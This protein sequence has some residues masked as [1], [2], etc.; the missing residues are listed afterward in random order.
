MTEDNI[1]IES[2]REK[3]T[4]GTLYVMRER[5]Y[6]TGQELDYYKIGIVRGVKDVDDRLKDHLT[7]NPRD[8]FTVREFTSL[9]VQKLET[10]LH[11]LYAAHRVHSGEWFTLT[12]SEVG[13]LLDEIPKWQ[14]LIDSKYLEIEGKPLPKGPGSEQIIQPDENTSE[15]AQNLAVA[16][17]ELKIAKANKSLVS[18]K[19]VE[20]AGDNPEFAAMFKTSTSNS[21]GSFSSG[22]VEARDKALWESFMTL[23]S[24]TVAPKWTVSTPEG[25]K[26]TTNKI[27]RNA[28]TDNPSELHELF[29]EAWGVEYRWKLE[30]DLIEDVLLVRAA[31][32]A[33]IE[34]IF[35]W[36]T[37][38]SKGFDKEGF[39]LKHP[40]I[41]E[42]CIPP[43]KTT[44]KPIPAEW[45][46]YV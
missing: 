32:A 44:T 3:V 33:G 41:Y 11:N 42:E 17:A 7:G 6:L 46:S 30:S 31:D 23:T 16:L 26:P 34:G 9:A 25:F 43:K 38:E 39:K 22:K 24:P 37:G 14:Q 27:D 10:L 8:I 13:N 29:M 20:V 19:L 2:P 18:K 28:L 1:E 15:L 45:K 40:D 5:D 35:T 21:G 4:H 12:D 36:E